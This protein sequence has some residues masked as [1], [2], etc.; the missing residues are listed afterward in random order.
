MR[1]ERAPRYARPLEHASGRWGLVTRAIGVAALTA[2]AAQDRALS[3]VLAMLAAIYVVV[4]RAAAGRVAALTE[5]R[6]LTLCHACSVLL[7]DVVGA[8]CQFV[9]STHDKLKPITFAA[10][11]TTHVDTG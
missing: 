6:A 3:L 4:N 11:A 9:A 1:V 7:A 10:L 5:F 2:L 8:V